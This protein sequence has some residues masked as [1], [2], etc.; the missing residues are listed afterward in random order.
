VDEEPAR[1][2]FIPLEARR[3]SL[4][5]CSRFAMGADAGSAIRSDVATVGRNEVEEGGGA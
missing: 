4:V 1:G 5:R 2:G 3:L